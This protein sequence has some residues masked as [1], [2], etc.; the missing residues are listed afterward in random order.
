MKFIVLAVTFG[1]SLLLGVQAMPASRL[2]CYRKALK[3]GNCHNL[4]EGVA[5]LTQV[6]G[7]VQDHFWDGKGC[8]MICYCN[9]SE[10][11]C[12]PNSTDG[13]QNTDVQEDGKR[14][15]DGCQHAGQNRRGSA[16]PA[17]AAAALEADTADAVRHP[18]TP[19]AARRA[20]LPSRSGLGRSRNEISADRGVGPGR[21]PLPRNR[22]SDSLGP[23]PA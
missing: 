2:S 8:E 14:D 15:P 10:L 1:L 12:C 3:D 17:F 5:D 21:T 6:D 13:Q 11:L 20:P 22:G 7:N 19:P 23:A 16:L 18:G 9:F 4:P